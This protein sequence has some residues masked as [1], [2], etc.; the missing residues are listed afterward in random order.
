MCKI[1]Q[2]NA[3]PYKK[4]DFGNQGDLSTRGAMSYGDSPYFRE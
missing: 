1:K 3:K 4:G 2:N